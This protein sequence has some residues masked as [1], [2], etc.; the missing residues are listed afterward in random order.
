[1]KTLREVYKDD[2][3]ARFE[4]KSTDELVQLIRISR[5]IMIGCHSCERAEL[6]DDVSV[7]RS[8]LKE[9]RGK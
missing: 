7:F 6:L 3:R 1:M 5:R 4:R 2:V 9:R 8:L